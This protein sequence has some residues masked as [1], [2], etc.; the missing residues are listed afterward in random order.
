MSPA[1]HI[2]LDLIAIGEAVAGYVDAINSGRILAA[3]GPR[4]RLLGLGLEVYLRW[5]VSSRGV[6]HTE[7]KRVRGGTLA[8]PPLDWNP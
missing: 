8:G 5:P 4:R 6:A 3:D 1:P 7:T 2:Q